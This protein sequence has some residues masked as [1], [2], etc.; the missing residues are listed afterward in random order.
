MGLTFQMLNQ[1]RRIRGLIFP[2]I[3]KSQ[4]KKSGVVVGEVHLLFY[5]CWTVALLSY[6]GSGAHAY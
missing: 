2:Q 6:S 4:R 5:C 1:G 3:R